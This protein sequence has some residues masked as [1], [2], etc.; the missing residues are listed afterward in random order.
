MRQVTVTIPDEYY[1]NLLQFLKPIPN[2]VVDNRQEEYNRSIEKMVLERIENSK[3]EDY[4][5]WEESKK[6]LDA[7]W[8]K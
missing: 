7:K 3:P 6:R 1:E 4:V 5:S 2:A 8:L